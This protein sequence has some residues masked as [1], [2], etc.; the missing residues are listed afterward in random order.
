L[1]IP[2]YSLVI[3]KDVKSQVDSDE[4][5]RKITLLRK[6]DI[7]IDHLDFDYV[8]SCESAKEIEKILKILRLDSYFFPFHG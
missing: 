3:M 1:L 5:S 4:K 8:K 2:L 6:Y 7:P